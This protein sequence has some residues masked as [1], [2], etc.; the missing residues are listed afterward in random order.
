M[1]LIFTTA[2]RRCYRRFEDA[3]V[4]KAWQTP[5]MVMVMVRQTATA[6]LAFV[7]CSPCHGRGWSE[8]YEG[9]NT[10]AMM[11]MPPCPSCHGSGMADML[12]EN[13]RIYG[14]R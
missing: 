6:K 13:L 11:T 4:G 9:S 12:Y 8:Y 10:K 2:M 5:L 7:A 1:L 3:T 14:D